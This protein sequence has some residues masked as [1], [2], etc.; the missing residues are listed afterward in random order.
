MNSSDALF[1]LT[2]L[3]KD[4]GW[5]RPTF[6]TTVNVPWVILCAGVN[7][8]Q[9]LNHGGPSQRHIEAA[10][11]DLHLFISNSFVSSKI[12]DS[13]DNFDFDTINFPILDDDVPRSPSYG[14][15][16]SH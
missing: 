1:S 4:F 14:R 6:D 13:R 3:K 10:F 16:S 8:N 11:L 2:Y 7:E 5:T 15:V 12:Y 9:Q